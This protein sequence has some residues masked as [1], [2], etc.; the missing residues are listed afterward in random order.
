MLKVENVIKQYR[1][2]NVVNDVSITLSKGKVYGLVGINGCGKSTLMKIICTLV[3]PQSG[4]VTWDGDEI[5]E[6]KN[7]GLKIGYMIES[8][9]FFGNLSGYDNLA[10]LAELYD[11]VTKSDINRVL[12][13][14]GLTPNAKKRYKEYSLGMKQRLYFSYALINEPNLLI[15][16]EPFNG[17]DPVTNVIF[18]KII[19]GYAEK[20]CCV[21]VTSHA[22]A[23]IQSVCDEVFVMQSGKIIENITDMSK[24]DLESEIFGL[25]K[26]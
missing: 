1:G 12:E 8:P 17:I 24:T 16:D 14:T 9:A 21:F 3:S 5:A 20:G 25:L 13:I 23:D 6:A 15:L 26:D 4:N 18:K 22:I 11:G 19:K 7:K 10:V 2:V